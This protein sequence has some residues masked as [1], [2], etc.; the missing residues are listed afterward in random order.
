MP[1]LINPLFVASFPKWTPE[2]IDP[3]PQ[4]CFVGRSN[5]GK[6]SLINTLVGQKSLARTSSTPGRTRA[7]VVF[8]IELRT[9]TGTT[10]PFHV[11]DLPGYGYANVPVSVK[12]AW[13]PMMEGYF[14]NNDRLR[15][16]VFLL[17][18]RRKPSEA[19]L[20]LLEMMELHEVPIIPV[21][22]KI[23]KVPKTKRTREIKAIAKSLGLD[24]HRDLR[25]VSARDGLGMGD[26]LE[27]MESVLLGE[28][29]VEEQDE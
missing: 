5:V 19:D 6:S 22:T 12:Q 1:T 25:L 29:V 26:L 20:E 7:I 16:C 17:D 8:R 4:V 15:C 13:R 9:G 2:K 11:I 10:L 21:V 3:L 27:D 14:Q 23:D 18:I 24:D 28:A